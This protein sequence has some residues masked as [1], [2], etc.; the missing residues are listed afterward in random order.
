MTDLPG[1]L[2]PEMNLSSEHF[3]LYRSTNAFGQTLSLAHNG[4]PALLLHQP[5]NEWSQKHWLAPERLR[6]D[7][8]HA[9]A[10]ERAGPAPH[11]REGLPAGT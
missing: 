9:P 3:V 5:F 7:L 2:V 8:P 4:Y 11:A 6:P 10:I 1:L